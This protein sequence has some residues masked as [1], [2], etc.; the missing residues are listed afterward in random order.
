MLQGVA[1]GSGKLYLFFLGHEIGGCER[2]QT[3]TNNFPIWWGLPTTISWEEAPFNNQLIPAFSSF[4]GFF[5][6]GN[7]K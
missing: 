3:K 5:N 2:V 4:S 7:D 1:C 6:A